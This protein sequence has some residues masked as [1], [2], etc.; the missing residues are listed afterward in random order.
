MRDKKIWLE[1]DESATAPL[2]A[3]KRDYIDISC[4]QLLKIHFSPSP[5][6]TEA[7]PSDLSK[8]LTVVGSMTCGKTSILTRHLKKT[9]GTEAKPTVFNSASNT[10]KHRGKVVELRLWDTAGQEEYVRF[11]HLALPNADY[12]VICFA[13][14][15]RC[16]YADVKNSLVEQVREKAPQAKCFLVANKIDLREDS[17][18]LEELAKAGDSPITH[19]EGK[20]LARSIGAAGYFECSAKNGDGVDAVFNYISEHAV[21]GYLKESRS[22]MGNVWASIKMFVCC[23]EP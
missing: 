12:V 8:Q 11:R 14:D 9:F 1:I 15:D 5:E 4:L 19:K 23:E 16:S 20:D 18:R 10:Y 2:P 13:V 21:K 22:W 17:R 7:M 3:S 6:M